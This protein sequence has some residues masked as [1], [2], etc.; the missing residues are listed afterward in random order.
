MN[1]YCKK[2]FPDCLCNTC[3]KKVKNPRCCIE[4]HRNCING[5]LETGGYDCMHYL[6]IKENGEK[7]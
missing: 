7:K 1:G 3:K 5:N 2:F 4:H 6:Q